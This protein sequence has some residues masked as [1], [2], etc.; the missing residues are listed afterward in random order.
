MDHGASTL[1]KNEIKKANYLAQ[2]VLMVT[3]P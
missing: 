1:N 3:I 2:P